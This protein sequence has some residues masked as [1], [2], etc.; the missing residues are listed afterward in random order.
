[1]ILNVYFEDWN[2]ETMVISYGLIHGLGGASVSL[3]L[4][5]ISYMGDVSTPETKVR[6]KKVVNL[7]QMA[8]SMR[9]FVTSQ[10][11]EN[12]GFIFRPLYLQK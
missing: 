1:M 5:T 8:H 12:T 3:N 4:A 9:H 6:L 2:A 11:L 7:R 10:L